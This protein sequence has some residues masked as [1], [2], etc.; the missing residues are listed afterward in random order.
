MGGRKI[1]GDNLYLLG[2][3]L[4]FQLIPV[5][6]VQTAKTVYLFAKEDIAGMA[7]IQQT[8]QFRAIQPRTTFV[9]HVGAY[10]LQAFVFCELQQIGF[11]S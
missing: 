2:S 10:N 11:S 3:N 8:K 1:K 4:S 7:V 9:L 5:S 6:S